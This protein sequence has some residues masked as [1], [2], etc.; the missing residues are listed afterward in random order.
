MEPARKRNKK[1]TWQRMTTDFVMPVMVVMGR[2]WRFK[3]FKFPVPS[4]ANTN[5]ALQASP[6]QN[7]L[8]LA[9]VAM[10]CGVGNSDAIWQDAEWM[11]EI[12]PAPFGSGTFR[13]HFLV[14]RLIICF[15]LKVYDLS[16]ELPYDVLGPHWG[17]T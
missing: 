1:T 16:I 7:I 9:H 10:S 2:P 15:R 8:Q 14:T 11:I 3:I 4:L 17:D 13:I 6:T 5:L 12:K